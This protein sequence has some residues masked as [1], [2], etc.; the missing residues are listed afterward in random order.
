MKSLS[1]LLKALIF[2]TSTA[3]AGTTCLTV[4][5]QTAD[6][7]SAPKESCV[8][9]TT[10]KSFF[11]SNP[12]ASPTACSQF[13]TKKIK[14]YACNAG[15]RF[16]KSY[17]QVC[18]LRDQN[19]AISSNCGNSLNCECSTPDVINS[20]KA[21]FFNFGIAD[22][23]GIDDPTYILKTLNASN[24]TT[25]AQ[26]SATSGEKIIQDGSTLQFQLGSDLYGAEY[27]IDLCIVNKNQNPNRFDLEL[28]G[29]ILFANSVFNSNN[30]NSVS[31]LYNRIELSCTDSDGSQYSK[32]LLANSAFLSSEKKYTK[33]ITGSNNCVARHYFKEN[34]KDKIRESNFKKVTFQADMTLAPTDPSLTNPVPVK[35]CKIITNAK[36][37]YTCTAWTSE[38][39]DA[40]LKDVKNSTY[41]MTE[42]N[43]TIYTGECSNPCRPL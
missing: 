4:C 13:D 22:Y 42:A 9:N 41:F 33:T 18:I 7:N 14:I 34:A 26:A 24:T 12:L 32:T 28:S 20:Q 15:L 3:M 43:A 30:Y 29:K 5:N 40:F 11:A 36:N 2:S 8:A 1:I 37:K 23:T 21:N 35:F 27:F 10:V 39:S 16:I 25:Y 38:S 6:I 17:E 19:N 31:V